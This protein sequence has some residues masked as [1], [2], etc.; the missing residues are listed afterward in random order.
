MNIL[1]TGGAGYIGSHVCK[2]LAKSGH[3]PITYDN[4]VCGHKSAVRW[5]PLALGDITDRTRLDEVIKQYKP[6]A[7]MHFAAY[8]YVGES[9]TNPGKYYLNNVLG[10]LHLLEAMRDNFLNKLVFSSSCAVYG[11]P[12]MVPIPELQ[13][14]RPINP[15]GMSKLMGEQILHDFDRA[16]GIRA[17]ALRYFNAA[18]ADPEGEIGESH[19]PETH[20]IPLI[21][22]AA[23]NKRESLTIF[24]DDYETQDGT[25]IRDYIHVS[26]LADAHTLALSALIDGQKSI[27]YNVGTGLGVSVREL[28][29]TAENIT[30]LLVPISIGPRRSGDPAILVANPNLIRKNL[31]WEP[32]HSS[33]NEILQTAWSW[34]QSNIKP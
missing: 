20:L 2:A 12:D 1:V 10:T 9:V 24:G 29:A 4:L 19:D 18:G 21:F 30:G 33:L 8:A 32:K 11:T 26:D 28:I 13:S 7:V 6:E 27:A 22:E 34:H 14:Q 17:I 31:G 5:G 23:L 15:Y 16:H 3:T 25:C